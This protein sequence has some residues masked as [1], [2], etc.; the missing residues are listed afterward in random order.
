MGGQSTRVHSGVFTDSRLSAKAM[1][2][3]AFLSTCADGDHVDERVVTRA[4]RDGVAAVRTGLRELEQHYYLVR[5]RARRPDGT[6][7]RPAWFVTDLPAQLRAAGVDSDEL[8]AA[9]VTEAFEVWAARL[10]R[11]GAA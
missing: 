6:F 8:V 4:M 9:K 2:M 7:S 10:P 11:D 5:A 3:F 1:G